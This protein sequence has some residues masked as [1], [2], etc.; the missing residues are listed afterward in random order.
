MALS[1]S[2]ASGREPA[3]EE[4]GETMTP[5]NPR[6]SSALEESYPIRSSKESPENLQF[7]ALIIT[8]VMTNQP[9]RQ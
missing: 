8:G 1:S 6:S 7:A 4:T 5:A 3:P 2:A 9:G